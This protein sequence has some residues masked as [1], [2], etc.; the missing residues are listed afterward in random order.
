V[1]EVRNAMPSPQWSASAFLA[2]LARRGIVLLTVDGAIVAYPEARLTAADRQA[3][4]EH[5]ASLVPV[6]AAAVVVD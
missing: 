5:R 6:L 4:R 1:Q 3:I 2:T